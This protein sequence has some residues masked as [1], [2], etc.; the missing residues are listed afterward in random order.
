MFRQHG[1]ISRWQSA[2]SPW[3]PA[4]TPSRDFPGYFQ[5]E[6][7][8][9][10]DILGRQTHT[11]LHVCAPRWK[12]SGSVVCAQSLTGVSVDMWSHVC[13]FPNLA[14]LSCSVTHDSMRQ[15]GLVLHLQ[16][17]YI[18]IL[19]FNKCRNIYRLNFLLKNFFCIFFIHFPSMYSV[20]Y[21]NYT[22]WWR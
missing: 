18:W 20:F 9:F 17:T 21:F 4:T 3:F 10:A 15:Q 13:M 22:Q 19:S 14:S 8:E 6:K 2:R 1:K 5:K 12:R 7:Q 11:K 16:I